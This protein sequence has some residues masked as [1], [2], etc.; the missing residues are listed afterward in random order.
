MKAT[1]ETTM[2]SVQAPKLAK[3]STMKPENEVP[4]TMKELEEAWA[5]MTQIGLE[6][7]H[8]TRRRDGV[9]V[10]RGHPDNWFDAV[11]E[12]EK[13]DAKDRS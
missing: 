8:L 12:E 1:K 4:I 11:E 7:G 9:L 3:K 5:R 10:G 13:K 2:T 6:K